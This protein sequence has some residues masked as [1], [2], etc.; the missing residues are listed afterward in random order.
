MGWPH[1]GI[2]VPTFLRVQVLKK[3]STK[4]VLYDHCAGPWAFCQA[5]P[6]GAVRI[7]AGLTQAVAGAMSGVQGR[8]A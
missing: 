6:H 8:Q 1:G 2:A 5:N 7:G 4:L 3:E